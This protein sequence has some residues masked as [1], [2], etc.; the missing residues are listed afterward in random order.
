VKDSKRER[1]VKGIG[2]YKGPLGSGRWISVHMEVWVD[3]VRA[4][5]E[6]HG[7]KQPEIGGRK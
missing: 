2:P 7:K 3:M 5:K 6:I 1:E 4:W